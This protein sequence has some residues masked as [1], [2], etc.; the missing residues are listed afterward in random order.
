MLATDDISMEILSNV[1]LVRSTLSQENSQITLS[2]F[3]YQQISQ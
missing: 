3:S 1:L 2:M